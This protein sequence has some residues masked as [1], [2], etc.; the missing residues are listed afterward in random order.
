MLKFSSDDAEQAKAY[1]LLG[2]LTNLLDRQGSFLGEDGVGVRISGHVY[3]VGGAVRN[4]VIGK[5]VKDIDI[6]V[7]AINLSSDRVERDA[8]WFSKLIISDAPVDANISQVSNDFGVEI[9]HVNGDWIV[10]GTN[11]KGEDIEIA[12]ARKESYA[13]GGYKPQLVEKATIEQDALRREFTFN[14][15][16]WSFESLKEDGPSKEIIID[17]LG[18]G[19]RDLENNIIDTPLSP[20]QTF[21][22]DASRILRAMKFK[23]KYGFEIAPRVQE[24]IENNPEFIRNVPTENIYK[25]LTTTILNQNTYIV[26]LDDMKKNGL[27]KE[28]LLLVDEN[29]TFKTSL[30][31]WVY[32]ERDLNYLFNILDYGFPFDDK[33]LFL[34]EA[35]QRTLRV[36]IQEMSKE[37][38]ERYLLGLKN[39]GALIADKTFFIS[40]YK[41][42]KV[43]LPELTIPDFKA[44]YYQPTFKDMILEAPNIS[45]SPE[46]LREKLEEAVMS[47]VD[48][49]FATESKMINIRLNKLAQY[50]EIKNEEKFANLVL[51]FKQANLKVSERLRPMIPNA[52]GDVYIFDF[53]DTLFW[54]PEW[55]DEVTLDENGVALGV[56]DK[57]PMI[58]GK[59]IN[60]VN[61]INVNPEHYIRK[62]KKGV[63]DPEL[64]ERAQGLL[65]L[66][67]KK[68]ITD[69]PA[70]G[71][72]DQIIFVLINSMGGEVSIKE[73]KEFFS[74]K[75]T[76]TFDTRAKY[77]PDAVIVSGDPNFYKVP[78]TLGTIPNEEILK[79]YKEKSNNSYILTAREEAPGMAE[80]AEARIRSVGLP[81]PLKVFTRPAG[82][83]GSEYKGYVIGEIAS[84]PTVSSITFFDD[85]QRYINGVKKI[86]NESYPA[87]SEKVI[88][89]H[90]S[91]E[92]K[93]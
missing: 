31:N 12:F 35:E 39:P 37:D 22:D 50:L 72:K 36:N 58:F 63:I 44:N 1:A 52:S 8:K 81:A 48:I 86:L 20:E 64:L 10:G 90:V 49:P 79:I 87:F 15:L 78:D 53:D 9:L 60:L 43:A 91:I 46:I 82:I 28:I 7:D 71:K 75:I 92:A 56:S 27:L 14:T 45:F 74:S 11:V 84:Q 76:K 30:K 34:S 21:E 19:L 29:L 4:F 24:A 83:S 54:T 26:A 62:D 41:R 23:F 42:V 25:L 57:F 40:L 17:P 85:N 5:P 77:Y 93:P 6:V 51:S 38:Q 2:Y 47:K 32:S 33:V 80:G 70:L 68:K 16:L 61:N 89:N 88:L 73:F 3:V 13:L 69:I 55:S 66:S 65:P 18:I 67:L 59:A